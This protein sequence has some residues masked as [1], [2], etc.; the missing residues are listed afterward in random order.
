MHSARD[1]AESYAALTAEHG[2][3]FLLGIGVS[4]APLIDADQ[5]GRYRKPLAATA[6]FLDALDAAQR[7]VPIEERVTLVGDAGYCPGPA[8]GGS[9]SLAVIGA[10]VLAGELA[11]AGGITRR[12]SRPTNSRCANRCA[13]AALSRAE[14]PKPSSPAHWPRS[15]W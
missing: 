11:R 4:H 5:P 12:R 14:P 15:G 3:R 1:V 8:V 10:Y 9:T 6:S 2:D 13:A 7:P